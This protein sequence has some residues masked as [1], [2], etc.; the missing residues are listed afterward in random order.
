[1]PYLQIPR[2][3]AKLTT[4]IAMREQL[5]RELLQISKREQ[6]REPNHSKQMVRLHVVRIPVEYDAAAFVRLIETPALE[7]PIGLMQW[8]ETHLPF[9]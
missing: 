3:A 2:R 1:L 8:I 7:M 9:L 5:Q 6:E 4:E